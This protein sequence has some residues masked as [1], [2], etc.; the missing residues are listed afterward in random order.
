MFATEYF[1]TTVVKCTC[2]GIVS[3]VESEAPAPTVVVLRVVK[4]T[5]SSVEY[6]T[7]KSPDTFDAVLL[8]VIDIEALPLEQVFAEAVAEPESTGQ[9]IVISAISVSHEPVNEVDEEV[10]YL[11][12]TVSPWANADDA[13]LTMLESSLV[14]VAYVAVPAPS[15][16]VTPPLVEY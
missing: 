6:L 9:S 10:S 4:L 11:I 8:S 7:V 14:T 5:E 2:A 12:F 16:H 3:V 13:K 1:I 15:V